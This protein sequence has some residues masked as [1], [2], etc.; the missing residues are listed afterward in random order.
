MTAC[1]THFGCFYK[2]ISLNCTRCYRNDFF[3][4]INYKK[5][6]SMTWVHANY[7][8]FVDR[9]FF[10]GTPN[11]SVIFANEIKQMWYD[12]SIWRD[13]GTRTYFFNLLHSTF[14]LRVYLQYELISRLELECISLLAHNS[15]MFW[16][17]VYC[18]VKFSFRFF[19]D[20]HKRDDYNVVGEYEVYPSRVHAFP[21]YAKASEEIGRAIRYTVDGLKG[22]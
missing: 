6:P 19:F 4:S 13:V 20:F 12:S 2:R 17:L 18:V 8:E 11:G 7:W 3:Q 14:R 21:L 22:L 5:S 1:K 9:W 16:L 10:I 15:A